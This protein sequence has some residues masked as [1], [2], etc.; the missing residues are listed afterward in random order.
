[1][2][3]YFMK[4]LRS[5]LRRGLSLYLLTVFGVSLGVASVLA[6]QIINRSAIGAFRGGIRAI[7]GEADLSVQGLEPTIPERM[8]A[9]VLGTRGIKA[10]WPVCEY[11]IQTNT[12]GRLRLQVLGLDLLR[13]GSFQEETDSDLLKDVLS[14]PGWV[15][16]SDQLA[17]QM[18]WRKG[19]N[20]PGNFG[21]RNFELTVGRVI[22]FRRLSPQLGSRLVLM[23]LSQAQSL[24]GR[25]GRI[26]R[27]DIALQEVVSADEI[28]V[29]LR[30][31]LGDAVRI[32]TPSEQ[33]DQAQGLLDAFRL[34]LTALSLISLFV[35][36][37][38]IY[39]ST[40]AS[41]VRRRRELGLL[42]SLGATPLQMLF[43]ILGEAVLMGILGVVIGIP[44]GYWTAEASLEAVNSTLTNIYL[45]DEVDRVQMPFWL[46]WVAI[47]I[48][49]GSAFCGALLPALDASRKDT[50]ALLAAFT[51][52]ERISSLAKPLL[53]VSVTIL[54][55]TILLC[56]MQGF[57]WK[58]GGFV[59]GIAL[60]I[61]LPLAA[62][63]A[64]LQ[65][66]GRLRA[67]DFGFRYSLKS[68]AD[69]V[70]TTAFA[71]A[72]LGIAITMLV[73][74]TLMVGSFRETVRTW[75]E[76]TVAADLYI[77]S[78]SWRGAG[79]SASLDGGLV[80]RL[81]SQQ[82]VE[83]VDRIRAFPYRYEERRIILSGVDLSV[84][85]SESR[86]PLQSGD[87]GETFEKLKRGSGVLISEPLA[88]KAGLEVGEEVPL[89][90]RNQ[91]VPLMICGIIY[92]YSSDSGLMVMSL[93]RMEE[94]F[95]QEDPNSLVLYLKPGTDVQN[96]R[97]RLA[98]ELG[99]LP[100][101]IT[102]NKELRENILQIF[103]QTFAV[104]RILQAISLLIAVSGITLTLLILARERIS[105]LATYRALGAE[106][107][108][109]FRIFLGK[110][111]A[112]AFLSSILG[113]L[114]G[115]ALALILVFWINRAYFGWS[116]RLSFPWT[117]LSQ[118]IVLILLAAA[119]AS[120][121]P[122][123]RASGTPATEL[124]RDDL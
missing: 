120:I 18:G 101:R 66:C 117:D 111:M 32:L 48:G 41:L 46:V 96:I 76:T 10:A 2:I 58:P 105:E 80:E 99:H 27:I 16:V 121:Y 75:V 44:F 55:G 40:Q 61:S 53:A 4:T 115:A 86:Y 97:Q 28:A 17:R 92:D 63:F 87:R 6:I 33:T 109:I 13:P 104:V 3:R 103:D 88:R 71:V 62:P 57:T 89:Y 65:I 30:R 24:L 22:N 47:G 69:R 7:S 93:G 67:R 79:S 112:I 123:F 70:Q 34:N 72:S 94:L 29:R 37:F 106:R 100:L 38:L 85:L 113:F 36:V 26:H 64:V 35:A 15:A 12:T 45:L 122:A 56:W 50:S 49:V 108:Q 68:L 51:L 81:R 39:S 23:D 82:D 5:H 73:G 91:R 124:N 11:E 9:D 59:L 19:S 20:I 74:I 77:T 31:R 116:I 107:S 54:S 25:R 119:I 21:S 60:L 1:V 83:A 42:R 98:R 90:A 95:G 102:S 8:I 118:E 14:T 110:G 52:R 114:G 43:L 84:P 78:Q